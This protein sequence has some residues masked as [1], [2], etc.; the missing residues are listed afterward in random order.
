MSKLIY[1][2]IIVVF[3]LVIKSDIVVVSRCV[4]VVPICIS[5]TIVSIHGVEIVVQVCR[6]RVSTIHLVGWLSKIIVLNRRLSSCLGWHRSG[7][8][9]TVSVP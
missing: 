8:Y 5:W 3:E 1:S 9:G 2:E 6:W 7:T 4:I